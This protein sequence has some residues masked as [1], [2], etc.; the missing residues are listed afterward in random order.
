MRIAKPTKIRSKKIRQAAEGQRCTIRNWHTCNHNP[1]TVVFA[2]LPGNKGTGSKNHDLFGIF[3]CEGCH[4]WIDRRSMYEFSDAH[5][6]DLMRA[7]QETL[8]ILIDKGI[9]EVK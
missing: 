1:E 8:L 7:Y 4:S 3:A 5:Y 2:H 6:K 9:I